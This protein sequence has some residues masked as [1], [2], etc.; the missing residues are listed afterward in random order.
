M[1]KIKLFFTALT[2]LVTASAFAQSVNVKGVVTDATTGEPVPFAAIQLKG[3]MTGGSAD[4]DGNYSISVP[5]DA[6]LIFSAIGFVTIEEPVAGKAVHNIA[7]S[8]DAQSLQ[9]TIIV[10]FGTST[11]EA[12]TG[13]AKVVKADE[14]SK[15]QVNSVT[16]ALAGQVAGVQLSTSTGQPG[17]KP[18]IR[19]R[20]FSSINAGKEP[21]YVVDGTPYDGDI[22]NINPAD[23]ESMTVLKDAASNA[24]YG[25][26][27][28]NGVIMITTKRAKSNEAVVTFDAKYGI[29]SRATRRYDYITNPA[30]YYEAH[31]WALE[32]YYVAQGFTPIEAN[33]KANEAIV[34]PASGGGLVYQVYNVPA[35]E[36]FIGTNGKLNPHATLGN[37][38]SGAFFSRRVFLHPGEGGFV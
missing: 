9:E 33:A 35:G 19:I 37:V 36:A 20:G 38:V 34:G 3:T 25:A 22:A 10:A 21:L 24:L 12:F 17:A 5:S 15:A 31:Y 26:R 14:L 27:G 28:A 29:N 8:P 4:A 18:S 13:S 11:K 23:V 16:S 32:N 30:E 6:T 1:K 7:L 2:L